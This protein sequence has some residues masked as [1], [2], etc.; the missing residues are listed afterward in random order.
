LAARPGSIL[1]A[2]GQRDVVGSWSGDFEKVDY[3][4]CHHVGLLTPDFLLRL[5]LS[6]QAKVLEALLDGI[7]ETINSK[8]EE[9]WLV[10]HHKD[11]IG[12]DCVPELQKRIAGDG[13]RV[14]FLHWGNHHAT[15]DYADVP[16]VI[17]AGTLFYRPS[18]YEALTR[19]AADA[20]VPVVWTGSGKNKLRPVAG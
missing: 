2:E 7:A 3:V 14:K 16:N 19:L 11:G 13:A 17:L 5:G 8:P 6:P 20:V 1:R 10:V 18:Y 15:N 12:V 9:D 4:A